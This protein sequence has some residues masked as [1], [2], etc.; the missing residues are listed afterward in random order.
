VAVD[1]PRHRAE[2]ARIELLDVA[3]DRLQ[4]AHP[5]S[6]LDDAVATEDERVLEDLDVAQ[7]RTAQRGI[8][9]ARSRELREVADE[10][11][12]LAARWAHSVSEDDIGGTR[13]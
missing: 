3:A 11:A 9:P 6:R 2:A 7:R 13:P 8:C 12:A 4:V 5:P 1:E 10:Q